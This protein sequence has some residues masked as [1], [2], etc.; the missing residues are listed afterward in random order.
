[1]T[2]ETISQCQSMRNGA[3]AHPE[4]RVA[5]LSAAKLGIV[6]VFALIWTTASVFGCRHSASNGQPTKSVLTGPGALDS[7]ARLDTS[8]TSARLVTLDWVSSGIW[9]SAPLGPWI[10][11]PDDSSF[12]SVACSSIDGSLEDGDCGPERMAFSPDGGQA[13]IFKSQALFIGEAEGPFGS[14]ISMPISLDLPS[15][16]D[17]SL[18]RVAFWMSSREIFVQHASL[19]LEP[20]C[21]VYDVTS[22]AWRAPAHGCLLGSYSQIGAVDRSA[23]GLLAIYSGAEGMGMVD[24]VRYDVA[25]GQLGTRV[26][27]VALN[28]TPAKLRFAPDGTRVDLITPCQV[29]RIAEYIDGIGVEGARK[30]SADSGTFAEH[31]DETKPWRLFSASTNGGHFQLL[32]SDLPPGAVMDPRRDRFA[33]PRGRSVCVGDPRDRK[34]R[35]FPLPS[36]K[37]PRMP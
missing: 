12:S 34:P 21:R 24:C 32:R 17:V 20:A 1:M 6:A 3:M 36:Q 19:G 31:C 5:E 35:C 25:T 26:P 11:R 18:D 10:L 14:A 22:G 15:P 30:G 29:E 33:W 8:S 23:T 37:A 16:S 13:A 2:R 28:E 9:V 7:T 27:S 4:R